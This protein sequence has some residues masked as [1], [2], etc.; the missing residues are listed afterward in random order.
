MSGELLNTEETLRAIIDLLNAQLDTNDQLMEK[1]KKLD[2]RLDQIDTSIKSLIINQRKIS[3][4]IEMIRNSQHSNSQR[5]STITTLC[6]RRGKLLE[7]II[8][9][10]GN[11]DSKESPF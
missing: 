6:E 7:G 5:I 8:N 1:I 4:N 3:A 2:K 9:N 10:M 11:G